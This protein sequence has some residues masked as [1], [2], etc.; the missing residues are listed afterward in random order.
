MGGRQGQATGEGTLSVLALAWC[1]GFP[2]RGV[3][4]DKVTP[5]FLPALRSLVLPPPIALLK[6]HPTHHCSCGAGSSR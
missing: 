5:L 3:E 1:L 2:T 6:G 4:V